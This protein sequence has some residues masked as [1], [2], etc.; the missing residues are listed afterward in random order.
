MTLE[1]VV[2]PVR[3]GKLGVLLDRFAAACASGRAAAADGACGVRAGRAGARGLRGCRCAAGRR[4]RH[5]RH[6]GRA[7]A[8]RR[9]SRSHR[10]RSTASLR[11]RVGQP[12]G[13]RWACARWRSPPRWSA[14]RASATAP[15]PR[16]ARSSGR[17]A[18]MLAP[19]RRLRG[20]RGC[21]AASAGGR[22]AAGSWCVPPSGSSGS[23]PRGTARPC[24][25]TGSTTSRPR[26]CGCWRRSP[27][28]ADVTVALPYEPGRP[29]LGIP[30][31]RLRMAGG[32]RRER[33]GAA[34]RGLWRAA[35]R[36]RAG[37]RRVLGAQRAA[38]A[39][40]RCRPAGRGHGAPTARPRRR[41]GGVPPAA[42]RP[43]PPTTC[44][45]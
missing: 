37:A 34:P 16:Q 28:A 11:R 8:R 6:A 27:G 13:R 30:R 23:L 17:R 42:A 35:E 45:W 25:H 31:R 41:G 36:R 2:G 3:S 15:V 40:R 33:R 20:V 14:S 19:R 26:S 12:S 43:E 5:A 9:A 44:W 4:G 29:L 10:R 24:S 32:A 18:G 39:G 1:L 21:A 22:A 7:R 38:A